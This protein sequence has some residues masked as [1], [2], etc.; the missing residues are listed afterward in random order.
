MPPPLRS[1]WKTDEEV[2]TDATRRVSSSS[3]LR[4][5]ALWLFPPLAQKLLDTYI[6]WFNTYPV[7]YQKEKAGPSGCSREEAYDFPAEN[8]GGEEVLQRL[9]DRQ[10]DVEKLRDEAREGAVLEFVSP[11]VAAVCE[12][13]LKR[14]GRELPLLR[15][16][17]SWE[18]FSDLV[19][20]VSDDL[21][22]LDA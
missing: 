6:K 22:A 7:R 15:D 11:E 18:L 1:R 12:A 4:Q 9:R 20:E 8:G 3:L 16:Q 5:V 14:L 13:G 21:L 19:G 10:A 2:R 17:R